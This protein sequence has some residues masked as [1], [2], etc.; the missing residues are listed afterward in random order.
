MRDLYTLLEVSET[1]SEDIIKAAYKTLA[2]KYHPDLAKDAEK[3]MKE[4]KMKEL[5]Y[6]RDILLDPIKRE[7]YD[8][9]LR[10]ERQRQEDEIIQSKVNKHTEKEV[11]TKPKTRKIDE[12]QSGVQM[13]GGGFKAF[14][15]L[16][17]DAKKNKNMI[18]LCSFL[19]LFAFAQVFLCLYLFSGFPVDKGLNKEDTSTL[20]KNIIIPYETTVDDITNMFGKPNKSSLEGV[21]EYGSHAKVLVNGDEKVIGWI[22]NFQELDFRRHSLELKIEN[23]SIGMSKEN[24]ISQY[25]YPDTCSEYI[26]VYN[27]IIVYF[28]SDSVVKVTKE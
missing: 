15:S 10:I 23:I 3:K 27:G 6:A 20:S 4:E 22:D 11:K 14:F 8:M 7:K 16:F 26:W 24:L 5:N 19:F 9:E 2:I 18:I 17:G 12:P 13:I 25:G 1:A 28:E 21:L